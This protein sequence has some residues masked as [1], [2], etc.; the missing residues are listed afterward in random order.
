MKAHNAC[1]EAQKYIS[2]LKVNEWYSLA[3]NQLLSG[4]F[5]FKMLHKWNQF[6]KEKRNTLSQFNLRD[7][8]QLQVKLKYNLLLTLSDNTLTSD[9]TPLFHK[10]EKQSFYIIKY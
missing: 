7:Y 6:K 4:K 10:K 2:L 1:P 3:V 9:F 5:V 8:L